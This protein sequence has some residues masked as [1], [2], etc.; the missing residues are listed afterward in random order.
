[1]RAPAIQ[2]HYAGPSLVTRCGYLQGRIPRGD[3]P[4][5]NRLRGLRDGTGG[6]AEFE[7]I[8]VKKRATGA[9]KLAAKDSAG[10]TRDRFQQA[11][12]LHQAGKVIEA[13][14]IYEEL[15]RAQPRNCDALH[16]LGVTY[17]QGGKHRKALELIGRA[18]GLCPERALFY[19][20]RGIALAELGRFEEAVASYDRALAI[21]PQY[22]DAHYNR[23][24]A[25]TGLKQYDAAIASYD[26][27]IAIDSNH[28]AA[29]YNRGLALKGL[30][31]FADAV[32]SYDQAIAIAPGYAPA[33]SNR[34]SALA[35][36]GR[37]EDALASFDRAIAIE[38]RF[39][40]AHCNRGAALTACRRYGDALTSFDYAI[41]IEP[42]NAEAWYNRGTALMALERRDQALASFDRAIAIRPRYAEA[43]YN[44]GD[45]L[46][47]LDQFAAAVASYERAIAL[48]PDIDYLFGT[49][50]H[51]RMKLCDWGNFVVD[52]GE[53]FARIGKHLRAATGFSMH[54]LTD[55]PSLQRQ[56]AR[57]YAEDK[58]PPDASLG[59]IA[60]RVRQAKI[61]LGYF[62]ADFYEHATMQLIVGLFE[63]HDRERF[64]LVAFSFGP[65]IEDEMRQR[66]R[67]A[68]G[69]FIEVYDHTDRQIAE[70]ARSLEIDIAVDLKGFTQDARS[71]IFSLRA[72]PIQVNYLGYPG[73]MASENIDY[74]IADR[75]LVPPGSEGHFSE[76]I[77]F[78]PDS[79]QANDCKRKIAEQTFTRREV[80]LPEDGFV[81]CCFNAHYKITPGMFESW[82]RILQGVK[83]SVLW[84][85]DGAPE[86]LVN[87]RK[88]AAQRG[89][90]PDRL[91]FAQRLPP[92]EHLARVRLADLF[93][94][95]L[96]CN[97]HTTA[98]DALWA[99]LPVLTC[100]GQSFT[101]RVAASLLHAIHLPE[102]ITHSQTNYEALAIELATNRDRLTQIRQTLSQNRLTAP[103]FDTSLFAR[104][105]ESAYV[106]ML[107]RYDAGL[108]PDHI[109]L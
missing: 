96:P 69:Q 29:H 98:S 83:D 89:I 64:D 68:F 99:G 16:M 34:G 47:S 59:P 65:R 86:A 20:N 108:A 93:L 5:G 57:I 70:L 78:L 75:V 95:T 43:L 87:L 12:S 53:L 14:A 28:A 10:D 97:A 105:I 104:R 49:L 61:R 40:Q 62:S 23:G 48:K 72:A 101:G 39:S 77:A 79:Y 55:S 24:N 30:Q 42:E 71:G 74:L 51:T 73:T 100:L 38:P 32:A 88:E 35:E 25:L 27:A 21:E 50:L 33:H 2:I 103:L 36:L 3:I 6:A 90:A 67:G 94:D 54:A 17:S 80:E 66:V 102:L 56:T 9:T 109:T 7:I 45:A 85:L 76:K 81:F 37:F 106:R 19:S 11:L 1:V 52:T 44:R 92:A 107:Q 8:C 91:I 63:E 18:I 22:S 84:L 46:A 13:Q 58:C 41:S 60:R 31:R 26:R 82:M 15:V 4:R